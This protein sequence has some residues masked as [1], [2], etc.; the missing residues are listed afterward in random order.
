VTSS[1]ISSGLGAGWRSNRVKI[2]LVCDAVTAGVFPPD[3]PSLQA[4]EP[5]RHEGERHLVVPADPT[6]DLVVIEAGLAVA[7]L[8]GQSAPS[9]L[10]SEP[11]IQAA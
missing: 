1:A 2:C 6:A 10:P 7:R 8:D 11:V 4:Q 3:A 5:Q 9:L